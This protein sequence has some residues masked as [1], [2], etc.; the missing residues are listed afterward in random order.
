MKKIKQKTNSVLVTNL[1]KKDVEEIIKD[2][3]KGNIQA[4]LTIIIHNQAMINEKLNSLLTYKD[5]PKCRTL[6]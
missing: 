4:K 3:K 2:A 5:K 1:S 6:K